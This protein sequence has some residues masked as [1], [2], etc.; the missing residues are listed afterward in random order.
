ML[1]SIVTITLIGTGVV[2]L[3]V[4]YVTGGVVIWDPAVYYFTVIPNQVDRESAMFTMV[5]AVVFSVL[6][7][8][9]PAAKA[10]DTDPVTALRY[11]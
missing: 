10:A 2:I 4:K 3:V 8:F 6:G 5:G 7:A 11:E 9:L 1:G